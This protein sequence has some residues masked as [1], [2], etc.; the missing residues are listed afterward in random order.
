MNINLVTGQIIKQC[1]AKTEIKRSRLPVNLI[2]FDSFFTHFA[3]TIQ[4]IRPIPLP[5]AFPLKVRSPF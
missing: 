3:G 5:P 4:I 1:V 2:A